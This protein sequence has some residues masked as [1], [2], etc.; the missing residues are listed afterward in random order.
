M[1]EQRAETE[2]M[3]AVPLQERRSSVSSLRPVGI[4]VRGNDPDRTYETLSNEW[5][6]SE[7]R[8]RLARVVVGAVAACGVILAAAGVRVVAG[9]VPS[10]LAASMPPAVAH[11]QVPAESPPTPVAAPEP[12]A[13]SPA[14]P[15]PPAQPAN[16]S[17]LKSAAPTMGT[18]ILDHPASPG[19]VWIDG[20]RL[21]GEYPTVACGKHEIRVGLHGH[22]HPIDVPCGGDL[23]VSR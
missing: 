5:G 17:P 22:P 4:S 11:A 12:V 2:L 7:R 19:H 18:L 8:R 14:D 6:N 21:T 10:S 13:A 23:H 1:H 3:L 20:E 16:G 9:L 15:R